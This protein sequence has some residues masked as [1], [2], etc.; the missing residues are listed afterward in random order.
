MRAEIEKHCDSTGKIEFD[1]IGEM[2]YLDQVWNEGLRLHAPAAFTSRTCT[3]DIILD[4]QGQK[5]SIEKD[6]NV[7]IPIREL[8]YDSG[9][10]SYF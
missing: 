5:A 2:P 7:Y 1:V 4:Y 9:G 10:S 6:I 8:H 3:E